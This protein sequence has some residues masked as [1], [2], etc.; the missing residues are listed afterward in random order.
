MKFYTNIFEKIISLE[1]LFTAWDEFKSDKGKKV[2]VLEFEQNLEQ[3]IFKLHRDLKYHRYAHGVYTTFTICDP[4]QIKIHKAL[5]RDRILHHAIFRV[6]NPIFEPSFISHSFSCRIGKGTHKGVS[7][8]AKMINIVNKNNRKRCWVLKCDIKKFFDSVD[9]YI[10]F[11]II[12]KKIK[13]NDTLRLIGG[14]IK[15]FI[16]NP[17]TVGGGA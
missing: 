16:T 17:S 10:L 4:K 3:N 14:V 15:S 2:D 13:D 11:E 5:V 6:L 1:N 12:K 9:Q 8:L 7:S